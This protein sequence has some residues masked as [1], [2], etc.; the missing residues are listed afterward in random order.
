MYP[1][2]TGPT[3]PKRREIDGVPTLVE[4][5]G[6]INDH[7]IVGADVFKHITHS[8]PDAIVVRG[9]WGSDHLP[10]AWS[11][12]LG[13]KRAV[14]HTWCR[15]PDFQRAKQHHIDKFNAAIRKRLQ[16]NIDGRRLDMAAIE[17]ATRSAS[18]SHLPHT[19]PAHNARALFWTESTRL[20][21]AAAA[22]A[23]GDGDVAAI[24][25]SLATARKE[26]LAEHAAISPN[27]SSCWNFAGRFLAFH[28]HSELKPPLKSSRAAGDVC[29]AAD[30]VESLAQF[31]AAVQSSPAGT[32]AQKD[33]H[34]FAQTLPKPGSAESRWCPVSVT[35]LRAC[36]ADRQV[37]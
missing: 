30:R 1:T 5:E 9:N 27:P 29:S 2:P 21:V 13:L 34:Q 20:K 26:T 36:I 23:H 11:A 7:I 3:R 10:L 22:A 12:S 17:A 6:S 16:L 15:R 28:R 18:W 4:D 25:R 32:D 33:L 35:E 8:E 37:R 14:E 31:Y 19:S 24:S